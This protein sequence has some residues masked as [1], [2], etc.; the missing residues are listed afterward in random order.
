MPV[1]DYPDGINT[2]GPT[3]ASLYTYPLQFE[4]D[5]TLY[6]D[7]GADV[8]VQP[9]GL[10]KVE[11]RYEGLSAAEVATLR[12]HYNAARG[13]SD[14]FNFYHR[15]NATIYTNVRYFDFKLP[16]HTRTWSNPATVVLG[17]YE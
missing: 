4:R 15:D 7:G 2:A 6:E 17:W 16:R 5:V 11:I 9:C 3:P 10:R 8:N 12:T 13:E 1:A 14:E